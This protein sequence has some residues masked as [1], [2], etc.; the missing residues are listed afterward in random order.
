MPSG[1]IA[2][3]ECREGKI[4]VRGGAGAEEGAAVVS[5]TPLHPPPPVDGRSQTREQGLRGKGLALKVSLAQ[6]QGSPAPP[7]GLGP[8]STLHTQEHYHASSCS[9]AGARKA[10]VEA[11]RWG[12]WGRFMPPDEAIPVCVPAVVPILASMSAPILAIT[13]LIR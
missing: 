10:C 13:L 3:R 5:L 6:G 1:R 4:L 2:S 7:G 11:C 9:V 8:P 12:I